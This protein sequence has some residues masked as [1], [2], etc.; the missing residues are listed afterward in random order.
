MEKGERVSDFELPDESG[1]PRRL[2]EFLAGGPVALF[3]YPKAMSAGC[4][5]ESCHFRDLAGEFAA[6]GAQR[7]G[8]STDGVATQHEFAERNSL[9]FPLLSDQSGDVARQFGVKRRFGPSPVK[10]WTFVIDADA[11]LLEVIKSEVK[12]GLHA[13]HALEVLRQR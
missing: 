5:A 7:L 11:R 4:T 8:I 13:D 9:G 10:R 2:S 12:M 6:L 3:F 1:T